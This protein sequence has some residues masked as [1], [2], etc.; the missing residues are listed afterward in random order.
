MVAALRWR[1]TRFCSFQVCEANLEGLFAM[2]W[3]GLGLY[4]DVFRKISDSGYG[5]TD[6][7]PSHPIDWQGKRNM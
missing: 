4:S 3:D 1:N 6:D 7:T 2:R 5:A